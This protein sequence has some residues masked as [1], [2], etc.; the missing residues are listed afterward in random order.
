MNRNCN[1]NNYCSSDNGGSRR[2][3]MPNS[4]CSMHNRFLVFFLQI[5]PT[6]LKMLKGDL[7][8][9]CGFAWMR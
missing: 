9:V 4:K 2:T 5:L 8:C 1:T 7:F 6:R 3:R